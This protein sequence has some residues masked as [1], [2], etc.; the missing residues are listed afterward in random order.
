L[1]S[2]QSWML[3]S[4]RS[5]PLIE[6]T[7]PIVSE[8]IEEIAK[9]FCQHMFAGHPELAWAI[10]DR[11]GDAVTHTSQRRGTRCTG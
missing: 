1:I 11:L 7:L 5:R 8:H 2:I 10:A 6:A 9:Q 3:L 4:E